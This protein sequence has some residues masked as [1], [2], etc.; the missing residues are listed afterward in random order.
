MTVDKT[1]CRYCGRTDYVRITRVFQGTRH[2]CEVYCG[3]CN[4]SWTME[5]RRTEERPPVL[6]K[7]RPLVPRS[8][9]LGVDR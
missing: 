4:Q 2:H 1:P 8:V 9:T 6:R 3:S 5:D 7:R